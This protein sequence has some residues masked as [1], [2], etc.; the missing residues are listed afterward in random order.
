MANDRMS[1][2]KHQSL[3][4]FVKAVYRIFQRKLFLVLFSQASGICRHAIC[5]AC[6]DFMS[7][8]LYTSVIYGCR[9]AS[10]LTSVDPYYRKQAM[11]CEPGEHQMVQEASHWLGICFVSSLKPSCLLENF[12]CWVERCLAWACFSV[13]GI[14]LWEP[15]LGCRCV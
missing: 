14:Q 1:S 2:L 8:C 5:K 3:G 12:R 6:T 10:C 9:S 11:P 4:A 15:Q 13:P 7:S